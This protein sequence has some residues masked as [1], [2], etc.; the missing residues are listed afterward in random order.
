MGNRRE[1]LKKTAIMTTAG[2]GTATDAFPAGSSTSPLPK[3]SR[4]NYNTYA[5]DNC[6]FF[7]PLSSGGRESG[8]DGWVKITVK[9]RREYL[10]GIDPQRSALAV[11]DLQRGCSRD[12][13]AAIAKYDKNLGELFERRVNDIVVPN[14]TKLLRLFRQ[15]D[16]PIIYTTLGQ[17][18]VIPEIAPDPSRRRMGKAQE[19][20]AREFVVVK[21][22]SGAF[23]TSPFDNVLRELGIATIFFVGTDTCGCV[24]GT[25]SGAYDRSYQTILVEDGCVSSRP[26]LH[27]ATVKIWNY[28]GF[29]RT[30]AQV[31]R[32]YPWDSWVDP[33]VTQR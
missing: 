20:G 15:H 31:V 3:G 21:W 2:L 8:G 22:A 9:G 17:D 11:I 16:L 14:V 4:T 27:E 1:F 26:E 19:R 32:D 6:R 30:T 7:A 33:A 23:G 28:K 5:F 13:P 10:S 24:E 12:W 29:V 25:M 18:E